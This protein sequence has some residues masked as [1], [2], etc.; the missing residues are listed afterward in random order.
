MK[1]LALATLLLLSGCASQ[2]QITE[3]TFEQK[4]NDIL[5]NEINSLKENSKDYEEVQIKLVD[6]IEKEKI[7]DIDIAFNFTT[8]A[9]I[10]D[11]LDIFEYYDLNVIVDST[12]DLESPIIINR[13]SGKLESLIN[14]I[15]NNT[16]LTFTTKD[17]FIYI[18]EKSTY[19]IKVVQ[20]K[21]I[22]EAVKEQLEKME[23]EELVVSETAGLFS[24]KSDFKT[25]KKIEDVVLDIN[26]NTS[27]INID[28]SIV[29]VQLKQSEGNGFDWESLNIAANL[30]PTE[31]I[32][33]GF[34]FQNQK[35]GLK[36]ENLNMSLIV[37]VLNTYGESET[38]QSTSI[39]TLSGKEAMF[40]TTETTPFIDKTETT[41]NGDYAQTS[42]TTNTTETG[43]EIKILPFF[44]SS[45]KMVNTKIDVLK[46]NLKG[47]LNV[48][49]SETEIK[50]PQTE[51]QTF[52][53]VVRLKAG[54]T[55]VIG[56][57]IYYS[58]NTNGNNIFSELTQSNKEELIKN[59]IFIIIKPSVKSYIYK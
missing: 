16:N 37:N 2:Q 39:K 12:I 10:K 53:S 23:I 30:N 11:L 38:L 34:S 48:S 55:S 19:K 25:F 45:S 52:N 21:D 29:N 43:L 33:K 31:I 58:K 41:A 46:S 7:Q 13:Y 20:D 47:F 6:I 57:I 1:K 8:E 42:F 50:Q 51:Q 28:L 35:L 44:D 36:T 54:E 9:K 3:N 18:K 26:N 27:L 24:F 5:F 59:A 40:K 22:I 56:G 15:A 17:S 4:A 32:E 14:A 49:N